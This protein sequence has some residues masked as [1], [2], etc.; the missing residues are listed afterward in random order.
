M[1]RGGRGRGWWPGALGRWGTSPPA[2]RGLFLA[3]PYLGK[4]SGQPRIAGALRAISAA[5]VGV[6]ANL[7]VWFALHVLFDRVEA[8]GF[9]ALPLPDWASFNPSA[10]LLTAAAVLLMI[11][12]KRGFVVT[13]LLLAPL[14]LL[15]EAI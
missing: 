15:L 6:I 10:A 2:F 8:G 5:V 1:A 7:S 12:L 11:G 4:L 13:M 9:L 14:A 3:G